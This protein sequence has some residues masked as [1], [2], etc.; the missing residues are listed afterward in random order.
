MLEGSEEARQCAKNC[1]RLAVV[2]PGEVREETLGAQVADDRLSEEVDSQQLLRRG[3]SRLGDDPARPGRR[4]YQAGISA[5]AES[6]G[7]GWAVPPKTSGRG[8]EQS[9]TVRTP[10]AEAG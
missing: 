1:C 2:A 10:K 3:A 4:E 5:Q 6:I 7:S 9:S 8:L